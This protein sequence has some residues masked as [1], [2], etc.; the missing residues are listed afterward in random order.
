[1]GPDD[2]SVN[3]EGEKY[4]DEFFDQVRHLYSRTILSFIYFLFIK[5]LLY[6]YVCN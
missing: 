1:M 4:M 6:M 2:V 3:V 5:K